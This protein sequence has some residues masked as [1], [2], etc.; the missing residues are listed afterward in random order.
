MVW[1]NDLVVDYKEIWYRVFDSTGNPISVKT[2]LA[3][4]ASVDF[5]S[6]FITGLSGGKAFLAYTRKDAGGVPTVKYMIYDGSNWSGEYS[7]TGTG[8]EGYNPQA[9]QLLNR[10][11]LLAWSDQDFK[12][13]SYLVFNPS[14]P[15]TLTPTRLTAPNNRSLGNISLTV[16]LGGR[17]VLVWMDVTH[18]NYLYYAVVDASGNIL[19]SP[20]TYLGEGINSKLVSSYVGLGIASYDGAFRTQLPFLRR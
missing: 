4:G 15:G 12:G 13:I 16:D 18:F 10:N 1:V 20:M 8:A 6:P 3:F 5:S 7:I 11:V 9:V 17:G 2:Q 19:T 14:S